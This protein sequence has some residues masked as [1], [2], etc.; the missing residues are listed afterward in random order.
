LV[1]KV[2]TVRN[3]PKLDRKASFIIFW[4]TVTGVDF[5]FIGSWAQFL[6]PNFFLTFLRPNSWVPFHDFCS[7]LF[8]ELWTIK[9]YF[10]VKKLGA[11]VLNYLYIQEIDPWGW[12]LICCKVERKSVCHRAQLS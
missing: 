2:T 11:V 5:L 9:V 7:Q 3:L 8:I 1:R 12:F 10:L 6:T 4:I